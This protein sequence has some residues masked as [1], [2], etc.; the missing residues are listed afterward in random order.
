MIFGEVHGLG[1]G[2]YIYRYIGRDDDRVAGEIRLWCVL[3]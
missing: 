2:I 1:D 3:M